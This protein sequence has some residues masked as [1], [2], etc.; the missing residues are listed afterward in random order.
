M[1]RRLSR[2][3]N[4]SGNAGAQHCLAAYR[5]RIMRSVCVLIHRRGE[6]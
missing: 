6:A 4:T 5:Y 2:I 3:V 1:P